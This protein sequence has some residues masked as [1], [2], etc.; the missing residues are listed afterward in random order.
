MFCF[1]PAGYGVEQLLAYVKTNYNNS[2]IHVFDK[3]YGDC[4]TL[5]DEARIQYMKQ[6]I[7]GVRS[8]QYQVV[9]S[10]KYESEVMII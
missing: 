3:G 5:Y 8:G 4:G 10:H 6:F 1:R 9:V 2:V 7:R